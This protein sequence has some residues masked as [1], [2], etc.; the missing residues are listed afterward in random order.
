MDSKRLETRL[1]PPLLVAVLGIA[2][3]LL[4]R[5][6]P[7][8]DWS[9]PRSTW[10]VTLLIATGMCCNLVPKRMFR[11]AGTTAN[12]L[13]PQ[14]T[15][16]LVQSGLHR[17]SRNPMYLGHALILAG[18]ALHLQW[19]PAWLAVPIYV[20]YITRFQILPEERALAARFG[21]EY[22]AYCARVRRWL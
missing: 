13:R 10:A 15:S 8:A 20:V 5:Y 3:W 11:R 6:A 18:W 21:A 4:A 9:A 12:P 14:A 7:A 1:P 22:A 2:M 19:W 16:R 17:I